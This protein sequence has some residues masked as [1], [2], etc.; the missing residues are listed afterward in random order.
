MRG[1][2]VINLVPQSS[3]VDAG[4]TDRQRRLDRAQRWGRNVRRC[5]ETYDLSPTL[6]APKD[7]ILLFTDRPAHNSAKLVLVVRLQ[8]ATDKIVLKII[9]VKNSVPE[10]LKDIPMPVARAGL[11]R[12]VD[13]AATEAPVLRVVG[14][15]HHFEFLDGLHIGG[16]LP[17]AVVVTYGSAVQ[18][19]NVLALPGAVDFIFVVHVP[20]ACPRKTTRPKALLRE[21]HAG[22]EGHQHIS[23]PPVER[24]FLRFDRIEDQAAIP[25]PTFQNLLLAVP[26]H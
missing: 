8:R 22:R 15:G 18:Q 23:L 5:G 3:K 14:V 9:S 21:E 24:I 4:Y 17:R 16:Q 6:E 12:S 19:E 20:A 25:R 10:I 13:Y 26:T 11:H 2:W 7:K 1:H